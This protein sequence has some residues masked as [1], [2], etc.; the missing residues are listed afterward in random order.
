LLDTSVIISILQKK[1]TEPKL[2]AVRTDNAAISI[3]TFVEVCRFF[4]HAGRMREWEEVKATLANYPALPITA[5]V[6]ERAAEASAKK[7]LSLADS[8]IYATAVTD[9][10]TLVTRDNEFRKLPNIV[11]I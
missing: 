5:E 3:I 10:R 9:G 7:G 1:L 8:I 2:Q 11:L 6:G 4:H